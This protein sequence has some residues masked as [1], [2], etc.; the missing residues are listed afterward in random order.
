MANS[1][2]PKV[3]SNVELLSVG[4]EYKLFANVVKSL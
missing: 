4:C 2:D 3:R 1:V